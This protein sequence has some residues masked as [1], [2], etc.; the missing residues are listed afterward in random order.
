M[1]FLSSQVPCQQQARLWMC[2]PPA[3]LTPHVMT[4]LMA[5]EKSVTAS[6]GLLEMEEPS[7]KVGKAFFVCD[8]L[9]NFSVMR[10]WFYNVYCSCV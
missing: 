7:V 1:I 3:T 6:M 4:R 8:Y 10:N 5:L 2:V 9:S